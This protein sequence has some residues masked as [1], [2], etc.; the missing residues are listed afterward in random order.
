M[1][2]DFD[3]TCDSPV[4]RNL[5]APLPAPVEILPSEPISVATQTS[6]TLAAMEPILPPRHRRTKEEKAYD[7]QRLL[8]KQRREA[9]AKLKPGEKETIWICQFCEF[10]SI[11]GYAP[12]A[13]ING[14]TERVRAA[15]RAALE[16]KRLLEKARSKGKK[17]KKAQSKT[18]SH[19]APLPLTDNKITPTLQNGAKTG[20]D[21][22]IGPGSSSCTCCDHRRDKEDRDR[23]HRLTSTQRPAPPPPPSA[24]QNHH[25]HH[26]HH[27][28][29][30]HHDHHHH[31]RSYSHAESDEDAS[32]V[33]ANDA[34]LATLT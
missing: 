6:P 31:Q 25:H 10:E 17:K 7:R 21:K 13:L 11:F 4:S 1:S 30:L 29:T 18:S 33:T 26:H 19:S 15:R 14:Y 34:I 24:S 22:A 12:L 27:H 5:P 16:R 20:I 23:R 32:V 8:A 9:R 2:K 28:H 3:F